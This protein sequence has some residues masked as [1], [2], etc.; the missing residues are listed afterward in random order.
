[1]TV[2][3]FV[4]VAIG[5]G[6]FAVAIASLV[7]GVVNLFRLYDRKFFQ[8]PTV[9]TYHEPVMTALTI[10]SGVVGILLAVLSLYLLKHVEDGFTSGGVTVLL[11]LS[12]MTAAT[13]LWLPSVHANEIDIADTGLR[14]PY[15][16]MLRDQ[17]MTIYNATSAPMTVC[18][19]AG[20]RCVSHAFAPPELNAGLRLAPGQAVDLNVVGGGEEPEKDIPMAGLDWAA[21]GVTIATPAPGMTDVDTSIHA[22]MLCT[23]FGPSADC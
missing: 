22:E 20:S 19:G 8:T 16:I 11:T 6:I 14:Q 21:Y 10:A 1:M 17:R 3:Q 9:G 18:T 23:D 4:T 12:I 15:Y 7:F 5:L 13:G 2:K